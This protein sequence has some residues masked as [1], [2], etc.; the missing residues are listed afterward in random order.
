MRCPTRRQIFAAYSDNPGQTRSAIQSVQR[1]RVGVIMSYKIRDKENIEGYLVWYKLLSGEF[2]QIGHLFSDSSLAQ[3]EADRL[4]DSKVMTR[5]G[6]KTIHTGNPCPKCGHE[7][8][9]TAK[10]QQHMD[11]CTEYRCTNEKCEHEWRYT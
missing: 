1:D 2:V 9:I 6:L 4:P 11:D 5:Y 8:K 10:Y 3:L 7:G